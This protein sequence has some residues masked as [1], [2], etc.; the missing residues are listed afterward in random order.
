MPTTLTTATK[1]RVWVGG[2]WYGASFNMIRCHE[3][4]FISAYSKSEKGSV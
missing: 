1:L 4:V 2:L 3:F